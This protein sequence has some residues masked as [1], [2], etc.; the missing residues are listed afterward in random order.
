MDKLLTT[1]DFQKK[2]LLDISNLLDKYKI[3]HCLMYG[4]LLGAVRNND[5][6][7]NY[8]LDLGIFY[9]FWKNDNIWYDFNMDLQ[10]IGY[11]VFAMTYNLVWIEFIEFHQVYHIDLFLLERTKQFYI[12]ESYGKLSYF[13][14]K[15]FDYLEEKLFCDKKFKIPPDVESHLERNYGL[16]W[17]IP[18]PKDNNCNSRVDI[19]NTGNMLRFAYEIWVLEKDKINKKQHYTLG[20]VNDEFPID[21]REHHKNTNESIIQ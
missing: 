15:D 3:V 1:K 4:T 9:Q 6:I 8:D 18:K 13:P 16:D 20:D 12:T 14:L 19:M 2:M 21:P 11:R 10:K 5:F 7:E 17:R